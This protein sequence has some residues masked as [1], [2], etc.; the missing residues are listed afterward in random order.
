MNG[1][2]QHFWRCSKHIGGINGQFVK[3]LFYVPRQRVKY[4]NGFNFISKKVNLKGMVSIAWKNVNNISIYTKVTVQK[5][6]SST[7]V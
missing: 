3:V 1:V 2:L 7:C 5:I 6:G 4:F